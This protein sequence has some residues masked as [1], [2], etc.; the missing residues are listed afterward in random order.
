MSFTITG[1]ESI[2][3]PIGTE[4]QSNAPVIASWVASTRV[5]EAPTCTRPFATAGDDVATSV[6]LDQFTAPVAA[7]RL[8]SDAGAD[9]A[10]HSATY[11][12]PPTTA[13]EL[14]ALG[15]AACDPGTT[16]FQTSIPLALSSARTVP[17][18]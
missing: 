16:V 5:P 15:H 9:C 3:A 11:T 1:D 12:A 2:S 14:T 4:R 10:G 8:K 18:A 7:L 13:G 6:A 17:V